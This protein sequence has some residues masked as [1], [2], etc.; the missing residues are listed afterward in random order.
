[1]YHFIIAIIDFIYNKCKSENLGKYVSSIVYLAYEIEIITEDFFTKYA[2]TNM[3]YMPL[4]QSLFGNQEFE[5][6]F[7]NDTIDFKNWLRYL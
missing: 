2:L 3:R 5:E 6:K 1:M 7:F 4:K